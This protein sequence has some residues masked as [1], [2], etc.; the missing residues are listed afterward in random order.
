MRLGDETGNNARLV[1]V[2]LGPAHG[3]VSA[4]VGAAPDVLSI[5]AAL[6]WLYVAAE[7]GDL[8]VFDLA[9]PG[10]VAIDAEQPGPSAH[11]VA[12]DP[13]THRV[14]FPLSQGPGGAPVVR[15]MGPS[16]T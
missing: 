13:A 4:P 2:D 5:D 10:L 16:G 12:A 6:G 8:T 3:A 15:V 14:Y 1:R 9:R 7:S 11:A